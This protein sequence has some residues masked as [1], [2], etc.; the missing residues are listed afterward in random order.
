MRRIVAVAMGCA[1]L[2]CAVANADTMVT[3]DPGA[4]WI[5]FMNVSNL[6]S[7]GGAY[8]FGQSWGT[9]DLAATFSG[10]VLT[11]AP[12]SIGDPA[13]YWYL[14][15]GGPG[16]TGNKT[17]DANMYVE[18]PAGTYA[19]QTLTFKGNVLSNSLVS[20]Y[21]S[22]AFIK[23]FAPNYSSNVSVTIPLGPGPF[24]ISL[25]TVNDPGRHVQY[26]FETIGPD[27]WI[28]DVGPKGN[29]QI[30]AVAVPEPTTLMLAGIAALSLIVARRRN[31]PK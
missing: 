24:S 7:D 21:T 2:F 19:G 3:V 14:P 6:P 15:S 4:G 31:L 17:M 13:S 18:Q 22:V 20:P 23:D 9:A 11:L 8:Q 16:S 12:N 10:P 28:T 25:A 1:M 5:G 27:V 29:V 30:T 26:G